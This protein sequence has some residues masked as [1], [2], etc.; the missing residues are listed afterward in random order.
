[1]KVK[2]TIAFIGEADDVCSQL[3][4]RLAAENYPLVLVAKEN[5]HFGEASRQILS[6]IPE[7]DIEVI[8]CEKEGCW[9]ADIILLNQLRDLDSGLPEKIM[10]VANQKILVYF[11]NAHDRPVPFQKLQTF[12]Q[13]LPN[14]EWVR[15]VF[16]PVSSE[17]QV[18]GEE[19][20]AAVVEDIFKQAG[21]TTSLLKATE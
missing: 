21:Y 13:L 8:G 17:I 5:N 7:A 18:T 15:A 4:Q 10:E 20:T 19:E 12:R 1:M 11:S 9:E 16:D 2:E 6:R 3:I 14:T